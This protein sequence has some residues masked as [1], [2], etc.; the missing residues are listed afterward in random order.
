MKRIILAISITLIVAIPVTAVAATKANIFRLKSQD[1]V[2]YGKVGCIANYE[3]Y[4]ATLLCQRQPRSRARYEV[5]IS[6]SAIAV[7]RMGNP[8]PIYVTP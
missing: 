4:R 3:A 1:R 6:P 7:F 5:S 8:D 2:V